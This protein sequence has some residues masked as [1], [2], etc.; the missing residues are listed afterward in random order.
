MSVAQLKRA[1]K[2]WQPLARKS[3]PMCCRSPSR[4]TLSWACVPRVLKKVRTACFPL[5]RSCQQPGPPKDPFFFPL[6]HKKRGTKAEIRSALGGPTSE[7][8]QVQK[9]GECENETVHTYPYIYIYTYVS[10]PLSGVSR[11]CPP[12]EPILMV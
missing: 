4:C 6:T 5:K 11:V 2:N 7:K 1:R 12:L 3:K 8:L 10:N 9:L